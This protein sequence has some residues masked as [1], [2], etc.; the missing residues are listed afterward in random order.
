MK[1]FK[2]LA[3]FQKTR[4]FNK[5]IYLKTKNFLAEERFGITNQIRRASVSIAT[6][7]AEGCGRNSDKEFARFLNIAYASAC[8]VECL[9]LISSDLELIDRQTLSSLQ[10]KLDEI[11]KMLF[12]FVKKLMTEDCRLRTK[13]ALCI[14]VFP[15]LI[16]KTFL[17]DKGSV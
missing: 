8:E 5:E 3:V 13:S 12:A 17:L 16:L 10:K 4:I 14:V 6:N 15:V 2:Q 11:K 7:I 9:L 1:D